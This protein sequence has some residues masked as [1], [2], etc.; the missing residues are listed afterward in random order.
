MNKK[1][2]AMLFLVVCFFFIALSTID[3]NPLK[4]KKANENSKEEA[5]QE[6]IPVDEQNDLTVKSF[7][8]EL[9]GNDYTLLLYLF[10]PDKLTKDLD[11][12]ANT[13]E[14]NNHDISEVAIANYAKE[15]GETIKEGKVLVEG[16]I[17]NITKKD[18]VYQYTI[19]LSFS[20]GSQKQLKLDVQKGIIITP[21]NDLLIPVF[22]K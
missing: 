17:S 9:L 13:D 2:L 4:F 21:L 7:I 3:L 10:Q 16:R 5:T 18:T 19:L 6:I 22:N 1:T 11:E 14:S 8:R 20:D 15:V 12:L